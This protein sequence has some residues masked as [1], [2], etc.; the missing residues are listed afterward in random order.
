MVAPIPAQESQARSS[1]TRHGAPPLPATAH[2]PPLTTYSVFVAPLFSYSY[3][4][5]FLQPLSFHIDLR[6]PG[7][8]RVCVATRL[9]AASILPG[10]EERRMANFLEYNPEQAY[11]LPPTVREVLG[12]GHLCFF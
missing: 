7:G 11:L 12:A 10:E 2:Y 1:S 9:D 3:E 5:L 8:D 6:C 4:L